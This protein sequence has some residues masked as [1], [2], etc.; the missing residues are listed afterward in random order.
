M[1]CQQSGCEEEAVAIAHWPG[2]DTEQCED[3]C[4]ALNNLS[5]IMGAG[6]I[7]FTSLLTGQSMEFKAQ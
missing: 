6:R 3:H 2:N 5:G 1:I 7:I 4:R